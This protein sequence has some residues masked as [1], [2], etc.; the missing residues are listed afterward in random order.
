MLVLDGLGLQ[1]I[2]SSVRK[3]WSSRKSLV[4]GFGAFGLEF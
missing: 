4:W 2:A 3:Q 1:G